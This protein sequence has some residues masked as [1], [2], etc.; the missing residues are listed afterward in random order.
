VRLYDASGQS[1][2]FVDQAG[3]NGVFN[4]A[5]GIEV[6]DGWPWSRFDPAAGSAEMC[7]PTPTHLTNSRDGHPSAEM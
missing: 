3:D 4:P 7:R 6:G 1:S 2:S 5:A